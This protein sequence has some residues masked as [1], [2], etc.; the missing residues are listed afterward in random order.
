MILDDRQTG[1]PTPASPHAQAGM[2]GMSEMMERMMAG[3]TLSATQKTSMDSVMKS[4]AD[5]RATLMQDQSMDQ[6]ARRAKGREMRT[7][8]NDAVKAILTDDQKKVF[9]KNM[10]DMQ[11]QMGGGQRPPQH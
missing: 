4:F 1:D 10:A 3:I 7:K 11:A 6:D 9:E 8:Q 2:A 5:Q